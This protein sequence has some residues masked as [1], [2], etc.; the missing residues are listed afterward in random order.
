MANHRKRLTKR[1]RRKPLT[2][3]QRVLAVHPSAYARHDRANRWW[4]VET[5]IG[6]TI[7]SGG[8]PASAWRSAARHPS[9]GKKGNI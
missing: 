2:H 4:H 5:N 8:A 1:A 7:G 3:R 9:V 6:K